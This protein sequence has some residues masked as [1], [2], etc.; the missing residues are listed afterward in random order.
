MKKIM[1]TNKLIGLYFLS[2][3]AF[4]VGCNGMEETPSNKFTDD[5]YWTSSTKAQYVVNMA[6]SQMYNAGEM[7]TDE[8][9][10]DN[11]F[12]GRGLSDQRAIR[13]GLATPTL[14]IFSSQ[15]QTLY[16]GIKTCHVFLSQV[17]RV[18]NMDAAT[19]A[20]MIAEI[21]YIRAAIYF[22][23]TNLYGDVPFFTKDISI[24]ESK[25]ISRTPHS[26]IMKFIH[27]E[28][29]NI[30][31][32]LPTKEQLSDSEK[33]KIT[34]GAACAL[35][36]RVYLM[37]SD[38]DNVIK[39][40]NYLI[41]DPS[42]YGK[43]SLFSSYAGLF[44]ENNEYNSEVIMDRS[45][46]KNLLTWSD[47][48]DM[49][50]LSMGARLCNRAP[51]Q[52]LV[53]SYIMLNGKSITENGSGYNENNPYVNR[54]PRMTATIIYDGYDWSA[55]VNDGSTGKVIKIKPGS[56][57]DD[58]YQG[59]GKNQ[60]ATGYYTR[61]Y[62]SPE[63]TGDLASGLNIITMRY[64]DILL[65]YAEAQFEKGGFDEAIWNQTIKLIRKR[66]GFTD[67]DALSY[68]T[69]KTNE[70]MRQIIRN[71]RRCEFALEGLRWY[72][73]KRWKVGKACLDGYSYGAK[74]DNGNY[75][76]LD[77]RKF[78]ESKDY[79]WAIPQ[80]QIDLNPN[81]TQNLGYSN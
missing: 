50:P 18:P 15:W 22:R 73:I 13:E 10:S 68:P 80:S 47:M 52:S 64:A 25:T 1:K 2:A 35:Q 8:S 39:Y 20:R 65:M 14:G 36:A 4:L 81:L 31:N 21:R 46:V 56:G 63:A 62:F 71:E 29:D 51:Q 44:D 77:Q 67:A 12:D 43:Y 28:L 32:A 27:S 54:D 58:T 5:S 61:K 79:L 26:E 33:G 6:Y 57:T 37:E 48:V 9:L 74:F 49:A 19:K 59:A 53:N 42:N 40:C 70:E 3:M 38:W 30:M 75:I 41:N 69:G 24:E 11:V 60:T 34:K 23:L 17:D 55:N 78:D 72:D 66:A 45:Y 76:T 16:G 7:W